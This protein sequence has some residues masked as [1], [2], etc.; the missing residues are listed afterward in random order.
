M[1]IS[2][3]DI[4]VQSLALYKKHWKQLGLF[5]LV[6]FFPTLISSTTGILSTFMIAYA[7]GTVAFTNIVTLAILVAS[8]L[9]SLWATIVLSIKIKNLI[10]NKTDDTWPALFTAA[11]P[12]IWPVLLTSVLT[13]IFVIC[14]AILLVIPGIIFA[15]WYSLAIYIAIFEGKKGWAALQTSKSLVAGRWWLILGSIVIPGLLFALIGAAIQSVLAFPVA[16]FVAN[17]AVNDIIQA[18]IG[19]LIS[20]LFTP[21]FITAIVL[22]YLSAKNNPV[23]TSPVTP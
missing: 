1:L 3:S 17:E 16:T 19:A 12:L 15:I 9:F 22:V 21:L 20:S 4:I 13:G 18:L 10:A 5:S 14:G 7:P 8:A 6:L 11:S 23:A 2:I